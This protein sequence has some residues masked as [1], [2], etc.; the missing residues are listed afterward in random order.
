MGRY[1]ERGSRNQSHTPLRRDGTSSAKRQRTHSTSTG[2]PGSLVPTC[3][4]TSFFVGNIAMG[5]ARRRSELDSQVQPDIYASIN[6]GV[7]GTDSGH[8]PQN[9]IFIGVKATGTQFIAPHADPI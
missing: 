5:P 2:M 6:A 7:T 3:T 8:T 1:G 9:N 4:P